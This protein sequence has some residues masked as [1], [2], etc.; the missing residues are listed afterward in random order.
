[1]ALGDLIQSDL[2]EIGFELVRD[3]LEPAQYNEAY[4]PREFDVTDWG[5]S[6]PDADVLRSH[7]HS[8]GFQTVSTVEK[9]EI[10]ALLEQAVA[11]SDTAERERIYRQLQLWN[12]EQ[13][14]IVPLV[15]PTEIT[16]AKPTVKG[17]EF[18]GYGRA[19]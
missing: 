13:V 3:V 2:R 11:T 16:V 1:A 10:D 12:N 9:P 6:G 5:F 19:L 4:G 8:G 15:V 14:L 7:L 17:L 18:D